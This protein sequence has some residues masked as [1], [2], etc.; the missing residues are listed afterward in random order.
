MVRLGLRQGTTGY[1]HLYNAMYVK[2]DVLII[3]FGEVGIS[4]RNLRL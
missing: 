1:K 4:R 3:E 2:R